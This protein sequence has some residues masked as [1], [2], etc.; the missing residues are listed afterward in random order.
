MLHSAWLHNRQAEFYLLDCGIAPATLAALSAFAAKLKA[1]L[2]VTKID[3]TPFRDLPTTPA[4]SVAVYVRLLLA[5]V[6]PGKH[7]RAIY[8]DSDCIVTGDLSRLW[9]TD[10]SSHFVAGVKDDS[11][12]ANERTYSGLDNLATYINAGVMLVNLRAWRET[13]FAEAVIAYVRRHDL[14]YGE[15]TAIN[16]VAA[17]RIKIISDEWNFML[18]KCDT[19]GYSPTTPSIIHCTGLRKPWLH[20]DAMFVPIYL[21]HRNATPF[22]MNGPTT[23]YPSRLHFIISLL[24]LRRKYWRRLLVSHRYNRSFT[25]PYLHRVSDKQKLT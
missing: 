6:L 25:S 16:A 11:A 1:P 2:N 10:I 5:S 23:L 7:E 9:A 18:H 21:Y 3:T 15:Q 24:L 14:R 19:E 8:L 13:E 20:R 4:W 17:G 12:W 22:P